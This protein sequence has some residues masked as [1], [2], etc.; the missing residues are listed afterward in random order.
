MVTKLVDAVRRGKAKLDASRGIT[1]KGGAI[2][3]EGAATAGTEA[4]AEPAPTTATATL[5][6]G[7]DAPASS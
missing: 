4:A 1:A 6:P 3:A 5:E 7:A 2:R